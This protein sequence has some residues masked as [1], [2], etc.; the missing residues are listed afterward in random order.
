MSPV[1]E[2]TENLLWSMGLSQ[3]VRSREMVEQQTRVIARCG[4]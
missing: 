3:H 2:L 1:K 4:I